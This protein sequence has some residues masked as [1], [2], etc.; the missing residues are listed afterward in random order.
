MA[1]CRK[2]DVGGDPEPGRRAT[3]IGGERTD[4]AAVLLAGA[5]FMAPMVI[6]LLT[7]LI[8]GHVSGIM[9]KAGLWS[10]AFSMIVASAGVF[11][12]WAKGQRRR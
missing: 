8:T 7:R 6:L 11:I 1:R 12:G 5:M 4:L 2:A 10:M 9:L 3:A